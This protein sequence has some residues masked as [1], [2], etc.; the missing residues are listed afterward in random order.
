M[1]KFI[2]KR[3]IIIASAALALIIA[4]LSAVLIIKKTTTTIAFYGISP[5]LSKVVED[6][7][8]GICPKAKFISLDSEKNLTPSKADNYSVVFAWD[9]K[10][11]KGLSKKAFAFPDP[12][13]NIYPL[14]VRKNYTGKNGNFILPVLM[15]Y[16]EFAQ[17]KT[18]R[19]MLKSEIPET[20]AEFEN[21]LAAVKKYADYPLVCTGES[22][23][24]L[25]GFISA[26]AES[27]LGSEEYSNLVDEV[28]LTWKKTRTLSTKLTDVL[29][30]IR[31][32]QA[33]GLINPRWYDTTVK[34]GSSFMED[35]EVGIYAMT[36]DQHRKH[37]FIYIKYYETNP[38]PLYNTTVKHSLVSPVLGAVVYR[39]NRDTQAIV[40]YITSDKGQTE[41]STKS[42]LAPV[43]LHSEA[44]DNR[45]TDIRYWA[46]AYPNPPVNYISHAA[47]TNDR[48]RK[49]LAQTIR[50]WLKN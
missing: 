40:D 37:D 1:K 24:E 11:L 44:F 50:D 30:Q 28:S 12:M 5:E 43:T 35:R 26:F 22:D 21:Y 13:Y 31:S 49:D 32:L 19:T 38:V 7:I 47:M 42:R 15:N 23:E 6:Q 41:L 18:Y 34:E 8:K 25:F 17:Y 2:T 4:G 14:N 45:T 46:A 27:V 48:D 29:G 9:G 10:T 20:G 3:N 36:L 16:F 39:K 33:K